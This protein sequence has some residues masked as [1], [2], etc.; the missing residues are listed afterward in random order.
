MRRNGDVNNRVGNDERA[1]IVGTRVRLGELV[2][3]I[4]DIGES[5]SMCTG[6]GD[7]CVFE[8]FGHIAPNDGWGLCVI[9]EPN[10][11]TSVG[12]SL[13]VGFDVAVR[14]NEE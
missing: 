5:E 10:K 12:V 13:T 7:I 4:G 14:F 9:F 3:S 1:K 2:I 8:A 11:G 6:E